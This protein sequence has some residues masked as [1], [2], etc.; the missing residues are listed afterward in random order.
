MKSPSWVSRAHPSLPSRKI[1][2]F[3]DSLKASPYG[4][5][6]GLLE[7]PVGNVRID[8]VSVN[9][10]RPGAAGEYE[11][12]AVAVQRQGKPIRADDLPAVLIGENSR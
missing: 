1:Y 8:A 3:I 4:L 11:G 9:G 5:A 10:I 6:F 12:R 2:H 7:C